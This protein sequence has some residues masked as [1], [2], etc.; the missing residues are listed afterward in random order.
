MQCWW[1]AV[2]AEKCLLYGSLPSAP[3]LISFHKNS[4]VLHSSTGLPE[5]R[6]PRQHRRQRCVL[7]LPQACICD[8]EA[9]CGG[10]VLPPQLLQVRLL[11]H[12]ASTV[13]LCFW[14]RGRWDQH[15]D[16]LTPHLQSFTLPGDAPS[17]RWDGWH[18]TQHVDLWSNFSELYCPQII[19]KIL[20][21]HRNLMSCYFEHANLTFL[22]IP[23]Q[24]VML[25]CSQSA[26]W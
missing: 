7:L 24:C 25:Y 2:W 1:P 14:C 26:V 4:P 16:N 5:K 18:W 8:G 3:N 10:Q 9:E 6:V 19:C 23:C 13:L 22:Y 12:H 20:Q 17:I 21:Q 11:R 15:L